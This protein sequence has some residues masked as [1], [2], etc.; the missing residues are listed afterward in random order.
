MK[1]T[2]AHLRLAIRYVSHI[3]PDAFTAGFFG[4]GA[5]IAINLGVAAVYR[6]EGGY[7]AILHLGEPCTLFRS[8]PLMASVPRQSDWYLACVRTIPF[9]ALG[10]SHEAA[11]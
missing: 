10:L 4:E 5:S 7:A 9:A 1:L 6:P 8:V 11:A 2:D 3:A